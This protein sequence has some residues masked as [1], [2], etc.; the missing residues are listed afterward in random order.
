MVQRTE[1]EGINRLGNPQSRTAQVIQRAVNPQIVDSASSL[2]VANLLNGLS[3][4]TNAA[5]EAAFRQA[6]IDVENKKIDGMSKA[7]SGGKLGEEASKAEQMG[8]DLVQSQSELG[9]LNEQLANHLVANPEMSDEEFDAMKNE[10]Y[11]ALMAKYQDRA[12]E[13]F[14][15]ISVKAQESQLT[16]YKV[17]QNARERYRKQKGQE[18]LNYNIGSQL[19]SAHSIDQGVDLI[20]QF[21]GQGK[22]LGLSEFETKD[23]IFD[24][25]KLSASQGDNRL[26][27]FVKGTDWGR[28]TLDVKQ[29]TGAYTSFQKQKE[30]ELKAA[31]REYEAARQQENV[32]LYGAGL[33]EIE[34]MAKAGAAPEE[35]MGKMQSLQK[36]GLKFS[37]SSVA[38]YLTMGKQM[39]QS[40]MELSQ[41][42]GTW[43]QNRGQFN[44]ATNPYIQATDKTKVL[45]AAENAITQQAQNIPEAERA[46]WTI[47]NLLQLSKQEGLPVKTIGTALGSLA[48]LDPQS[49]FSP[50]VST[51]AKYLIAADDQT[52]RMNVENEKDQALLF[53]MRDY[54][55]NNQGQDADLAL[56]TAVAR[57][58]AIR[59]NNVPLSS[60]QN[61]QI[62]SKSLTAVKQMRDPTQTTW[63]FRSESLPDS[64]RD[65][66]SNRLAAETKKLYQVT[67]NID[68]ANQIAFKE[69]KQNNMILTGGVVANIGVNQLASFVPEFAKPG[70]DAEVVQKKA[71]AALDYQ[72]GNLLAAQSKEDG[73]KYDR[74]AAKVIFT[75]SGNTY[76]INVGG[77]NV[78]TFYTSDLKG[79]FNEDY[80]KKWNAEQEKQQGISTRYHEMKEV[81]GLQDRINRS[82]PK[83]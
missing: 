48:R 66:L 76:Q 10:Q 14:K 70:E 52:I 42:I 41:N 22:Q 37:P 54:L 3:D 24:Q 80:F 79:Q 4:M 7:V 82:M 60:Q 78:G 19:D 32:W 68:Q 31:Q 17:Q 38:S 49:Q 59:D 35:I 28:Y 29:A 57:G 55:V 21:M 44:L 62:G 9:R 16:L 77:L 11:G 75:N 8:Y 34:N 74:D 5:S 36:M 46:D 56:K 13:V 50:A 43:Q 53:G 6:Q 51:W 69:F 20:H 18:T 71:V 65:Y 45:D 15:A 63:Y 83:Y 27:E 81:Q 39:S 1:V 61:K 47:Q 30:A 73:V 40:Q 33:A 72:V 23:I 58:Q 67:G 2:R 64:T 26:L 25:M 12:P